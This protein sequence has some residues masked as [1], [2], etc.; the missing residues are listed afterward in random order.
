MHGGDIYSDK[1]P[2][3]RDLIDFSSN[4]NPYRPPEGVYKIQGEALEHATKYP[5]IE[6]RLLR[7]EILAHHNLSDVSIVLGNGAGEIIDLAIRGIKSIL[8][9][10]P[11]Y[12]EYEESAKR[13]GIETSY[14]KYT[15]YQLKEKKYQLKIDIDDFYRK[16]KMVEAVIIAHPNNPDGSMLDLK[17]MKTIIKFAKENNKRIIVDE[18][19]FDYSSGELSFIPF[20]E[21]DIDLV[22]I[23]AITKFYGLPGIRF[24]YGL[25]SRDE[26]A[27]KIRSYQRPWNINA[28]AEKFAI[29]CFKDIDYKINATIINRDERS[30]LGGRLIK[31]DII[32]RIYMSQGNYI[33]FKLKDVKAGEFRE[34]LIKEGILV[35]NCDDYKGL[36]E[37]FVRI[38]VK[39]RSENIK[40][41]AVLKNKYFKGV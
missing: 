3:G 20:L 2:N 33:L 13:Y 25:C 19:F 26:T 18:T 40:L 7:R 36:D 1:N 39:K 6:Y 14:L 30:W 10:S 21:E 32:E 34:E 41:L 35:R 24:G 8:I 5:D 28:Y 16:F 4:A 12:S 22:I 17:T 9:L 23:K 31:F 15:H 27:K 11:S 37:Y 38:A 29:E